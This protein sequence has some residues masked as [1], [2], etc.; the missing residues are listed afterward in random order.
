MAATCKEV[1]FISPSPLIQRFLGVWASNGKWAMQ[2]AASAQLGSSSRAGSE[3][4][5]I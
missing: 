4:V 5:T 2:E 1:K 3:E